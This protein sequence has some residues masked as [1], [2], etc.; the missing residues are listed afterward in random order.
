MRW[1]WPTGI[2]GVRRAQAADAQGAVAPVVRRGMHSSSVPSFPTWSCREALRRACSPGC[3][4]GR[5]ADEALRFK[6]GMIVRSVESLP[7]AWTRTR[8]AHVRPSTAEQAG[9]RRVSREVHVGVVASFCGNNAHWRLLCMPA[10]ACTSPTGS[11]TTRSRCSAPLPWRGS[12][13]ASSRAT[14]H[15]DRLGRWPVAGFIFAVR[16]CSTSRSGP[17]CCGLAAIDVPLD[18]PASCSQRRRRRRAPG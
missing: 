8:K 17:A 10:A 2:Q 1:P 15:D 14:A 7:V 6:Q 18:R 9:H 12:A 4:A 5:G 11:S 13:C 16:M 3:R